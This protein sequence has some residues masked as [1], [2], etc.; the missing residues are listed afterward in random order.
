MTYMLHLLITPL[1]STSNPDEYHGKIFV[2]VPKSAMDISIRQSGH[3][4]QIGSLN[5]S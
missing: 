1:H 3:P 4:V 5:S 2:R